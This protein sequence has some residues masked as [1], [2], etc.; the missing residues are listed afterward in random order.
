[1]QSRA[2]SGSTSCQVAEESP[3]PCTS[4]TTGAVPSGGP[5]SRKA[6]RW[7]CSTRISRRTGT[8]TSSP[9]A[10]GRDRLPSIVLPRAMADIL[11]CPHRVPGG[12]RS[13]AWL[14][15]GVSGLA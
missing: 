2:S 5:A 8:S 9:V 3:M 13:S 4:T 15:G 1:V 11:P 6:R 7:P 14:D 10:G 12:T